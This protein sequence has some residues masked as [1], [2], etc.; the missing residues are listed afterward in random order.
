MTLYFSDE[1]V[2]GFTTGASMHVITT[3]I[4]DLLGYNPQS[5][6]GAEFQLPVSWYG[7]GE[8]I[9]NT[10]YV[11]L[12]L[13]LAAMSVLALGKYWINPLVKTKWKSPVPVPFEL[14]VV[15]VGTVVSYLLDLNKKYGVKVVGDIPTG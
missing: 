5:P 4:K 9:S 2:S 15:I 10:N 1:L 12:C 8:H 7:Y 11:T 3:Q 14:L 13:S 6:K